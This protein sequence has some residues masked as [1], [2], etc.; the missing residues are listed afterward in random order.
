MHQV[1]IKWKVESS[2]LVISMVWAYLQTVVP[3]LNFVKPLLTKFFFGYGPR[4]KQFFVL[5]IHFVFTW[6]IGKKSPESF[7][8]WFWAAV[9]VAR[10]RVDLQFEWLHHLIWTWCFQILPNKWATLSMHVGTC[11]HVYGHTFDV[12]MKII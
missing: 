2:K 1:A 11:T 6:Y 5:L 12:N 10:W 9:S 8:F 3:D 4:S 7:S